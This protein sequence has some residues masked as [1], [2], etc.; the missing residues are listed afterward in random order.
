MTSMRIL[1][2]GNG[3]MGR[4]V[5]ALADQ[6]GHT[7]HRIIQSTDN[8]GGRALTAAAV[9]G[10]DV[11]VE[12]TRP[13]A[14]PANLERLIEA[15]IP[16]VTGTTGWTADLPRIAALA[17]RRG[18]ALLHAANFSVGVH[19]FLRAARDLGRWLAGHPQFDAFILE[20][21]H[22]TKRDAPS[23]T[24]HVLQEGLRQSD[25][26]RPFPIT[27]VRA[28]AIPGTHA[29]TYD[30]PYE[31]LS[32]SHVARS[33]EGFAAGALA[34]AEWLPGHPGVHTFEAMLFGE[35]G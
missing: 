33:R 32:L 16:T 30:G 1:I 13:D 7:V 27:S 9:A 14:A 35:P 25:P 2:V 12:F 17:E 31:T 20:E 19:L 8:A 10:A 11:A 4:A 3:R 28:G 22:A 29:V 23:G 6:R 24:A 5:A 21:H 26:S 18:G 15:G 34:A